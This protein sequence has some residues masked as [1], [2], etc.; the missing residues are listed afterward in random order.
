MQKNT[1]HV[2]LILLML[3]SA[4]LYAVPAAPLRLKVTQ[5][6]GTTFTA[7][8]RGDEYANWIET[9]DGHTVI[10]VDETWFY[11]EKDDAGA[12]RATTNRV[13]S[14]SASE[15]QAMPRKLSPTPDSKHSEPREVRKIPRAEA[16]G[17]DGAASQGAAAPHTQY[18][19]TILVSYLNAPLTYSDANFQNL[20]YGPSNSV[21][22]F[23]WKN[24]YNRFT[25]TPAVETSGAINDGIVRVFRPTLHPN[26]GETHATSKVE[27]KAIVALADPSVNFSSYDANGDGEVSAEE[28]A[29]VIIVAGYEAGYGGIGLAASPNVWGH[30]AFFDTDLTLDGKTLSPYTMFGEA[31]AYVI[32]L[33]G[34]HIT[35]IG[36]MAH[37]LGHLMLNLPDLY[38]GDGSSNGI[39]NWGLMGGGAWNHLGK[40]V[41][42][43]PIIGD[44]PSYLSAWS[45]VSTGFTTPQD[46]DFNQNGVSFSQAETNESIKRIWIDKYKT[47][48]SR[49]Y[50]LLENRRKTDYDTGL[51]GNGLMIWHVD[52]NIRTNTDENHK[53]VDLEEA[54]GLASLD[55]G[56]SSGD[57]ADPFPG[58]G[59]KTTFNNT[60]NPNSKRYS[61][62]AT[63]IG[64]TGISASAT[65]M[66]ANIT[67]PTGGVGDHIR[68]DDNRVNGGFFLLADR[69]TAYIGNR[70]LNTSA[71]VKF[72]GVEVF[73]YDPTGATIDILYFS[74]L[75][76]GTASGLIHEQT[77]FDA[78][79]GWNRLLLTTPQ[80]FPIGSERF[81][82][83]K[84]V[85]DNSGDDS[86]PI[87]INQAGSPSG[88]G[89]FSGNK[90]GT[91][92]PLC[93]AVCSDLNLVALLSGANT[94]PTFTP[95]GAISRQQGSAVGGAVTVGTVND[96]D[97]PNG[98]LAVT[99]IAGGS[100]NNI[101][102]GG[103]SNTN[104][105]VTTTLAAACNA[106]SGTVRFQV[107]DGGSTG[108]GD[109]QVNVTANTPPGLSYGARGLSFGGGTTHSPSGGPS[110]NGSVASVQLL[111]QGSY[112]GTISV[113]KAGVVSISNA[114]PVGAH[115]IGI[116]ATDNCGATNDVSLQ[117]QVNALVPGAP[118]IGATT[119]GDEEATVTFTPP[120]SNGGASITSY[121]ATASP[122]GLTGSAAGSPITIAALTNGVTYTFSVKATNTAGEGPASGPSNP[123]MPQGVVLEDEMFSSGF[124][125]QEN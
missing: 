120:A 87:M 125:A 15:L 46:I 37:E 69:K 36:V 13:G 7:I 71:N 74:S 42:I 90:N 18:V 14:L 60:S 45:K 96:P 84:V 117:L 12:L 115:S 114:Q 21:K 9:S 52:E 123:V 95:A 16:T 54:D 116:R 10:R 93:D 113:N 29:I 66:T 80:P 88:R 17:G 43:S 97:L 99:Q 26:Q 106:S 31:H 44:S 110:D 83:V 94:P 111:N 59:N 47:P 33:P 72:D 98:N 53:W 22:D 11:A 63:G 70:T 119:A 8:P 48:L 4:N 1:S 56:A 118:T 61:S 39:G 41:N 85:T 55:S 49:E 101:T 92:F 57:A 121:T 30:Q 75:A 3:L 38:D 65:T 91:Y 34:K 40:F 122:G 20:M 27:A 103:V 100:A 23:Y 19:L 109:L 76:G 73:V 102:I 105:T 89:Y 64:V 107:S 112:G 50:F 24:S 68:Y 6:D 82:V 51:P 58:S 78:D 86:L 67:A 62:A 35:T 2:I 25:I 77:G 124:E 28:L 81:I 32:D 79:P 108:T 5:P 104:G